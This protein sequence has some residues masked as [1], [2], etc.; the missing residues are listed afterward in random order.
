MKDAVREEGGEKHEYS[1][2]VIDETNEK[3]LPSL[4]IKNVE[5]GEF[6]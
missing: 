1:Y 6:C 5:I 2:L 3:A 4:T